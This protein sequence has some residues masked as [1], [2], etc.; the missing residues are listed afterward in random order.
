MTRTTFL[1]VIGILLGLS[2][3]S[4][5][6]PSG[7]ARSS[8]IGRD[9]AEETATQRRVQGIVTSVDD[10]AVTITPLRGRSAGV[11]GRIDALRTHIVVDGRAGKPNEVSV[12]SRARGE[13]G[14]DDVWA[15]LVIDSR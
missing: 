7:A 13:L 9:P 2:A 5:S 12:S 11:T 14:L 15:T 6:T 4:V 3:L 1:G 10:G 8:D